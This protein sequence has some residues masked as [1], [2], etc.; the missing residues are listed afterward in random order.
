MSWFKTYFNSTIGKKQIMAVTGLGWALFLLGHLVGNL[1]IFNADAFNKYAHLLTSNKPL[2]YTAEAGLIILLALHVYL[3]FSLR[4]INS[5]ARPSRYVVD[6]RKGER[7]WA[8]FNMIL[9]GILIL[10]FLVIHIATFKYGAYYYT[11]VDGVEMRDLH[12]LVLEEFAKPW[13]SGFYVVVMFVLSLHVGH[14]VGSAFQT[15]GFNGPRY[16]SMVQK[17]SIGYAV[18]IG[19]GFALI[20]IYGFIKGQGGTP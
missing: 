4:S 2:L 7:G 15:F 1:A 11:T 12:R 6:A 20:A 16:K 5:A 10:V 19:V 8:S 3:A 13:Y 9:T 18:L 14:G 17:I